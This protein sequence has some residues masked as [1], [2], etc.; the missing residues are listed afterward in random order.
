MSVRYGVSIVVQ[1][2]F[3]AGLHRARQL[4]CNQYGCWAAEMHMAHLPLI[5]YLV[6]TD[7][8]VPRLDAG[9]EQAVEEFNQDDRMVLLS[10]R[11]V[12]AVADESGHL[13]V[14]FEDAGNDLP[15][16]GR[17]GRSRRGEPAKTVRQLREGVLRVAAGVT[18]ASQTHQ[19]EM[20]ERPVR[21]DLMRFANLPPRVF[22][23]AAN[24]AAGAVEGVDLPETTFPV[25]LVLIRLESDAAGDDWSAGGWAADL[26]WQIVNAYPFRYG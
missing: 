26:R 19:A 8:Q 6:C 20:L 16:L 24:F 15:G 23:S 21:F 13:Y 3:I 25:E 10:R 12:A 7:E 18:G 14:P 2:S 17:R 4:V 22:Q 5:D 11:P 9:L 1:P